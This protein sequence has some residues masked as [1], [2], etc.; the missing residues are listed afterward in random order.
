[1]MFLNKLD[2]PGASFHHSF[3]SLLSHHIHSQPIVLTLPIASFDTETYRKGEPGLQGLIDIIHWEVWKWA[4]DGAVRHPLPTSADEL[5]KTRLFPEDHP[6][7]NCLLPA[8]TTLL[9]SLAMRSDKL[10]EDVLEF[11][12]PSE[13]L[14]YPA[15]S[16]LPHLRAL[17]LRHDVLPIVCG[18]AMLNIGTEILMNY[19]GELFANPHDVRSISTPNSPGG[20]SVSRTNKPAK[21]LGKSN[22]LTA[23]EPLCMLAWKVAWDKM[24]GWMT[25]VR[26]YSGIFIPVCHRSRTYTT[27]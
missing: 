12:S 13:F 22:R 21:T 26:V 3:M 27:I 6:I 25:F 18:S 14:A 9:E 10:M 16:I 23:Q 17:T 4:D 15:T 7:I 24:K 1:M 19:I 5:Q 20:S 11:S 2:R 8:R